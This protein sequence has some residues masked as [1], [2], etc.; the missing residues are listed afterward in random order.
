MSGQQGDFDFFNNKENNLPEEK[1]VVSDTENDIENMNINLDAV[2]EIDTQQEQSG[3]FTGDSD[4]DSTVST[5]SITGNSYGGILKSLREQKKYSI[6]QIANMTCIKPEAIS[7]LEEEN[8]SALPPPFYI[9]AYIKKLCTIYGVD[10]KTIEDISA[11]VK[12]NLERTVP[13][14]LSRVV[15]GHGVSEENEKRIRRLAIILVAL[16]SAAAVVI[17]A[18][19]ALL[20]S[21]LASGL[22]DGKESLKIDFDEDSLLKLQS[23]PTL[24]MPRLPKKNKDNK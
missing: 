9:A 15:R 10:E 18:G 6:E 22:R 19:A 14:D 1:F 21:H 8:I 11:E 2:S 3:D 24:E 17:L 20:V 16:A 13:E 4:T 12:K 23:R 7:A 5:V